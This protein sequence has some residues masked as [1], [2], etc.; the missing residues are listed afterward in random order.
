MKQWLEAYLLIGGILVFARLVIAHLR[1]REYRMA[2]WEWMLL[3]AAAVVMWPMCVWF[4]G[5]Y[6]GSEDNEP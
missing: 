3:V 1:C 2:V 6:L 5:S 4:W